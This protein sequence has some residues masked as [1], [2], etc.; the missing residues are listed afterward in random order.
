MVDFE[1]DS[2]TIVDSLHSIITYIT[3][4]GS[5]ISSFHN[6]VNNYMTNSHVEFVRRQ[7]NDSN[8]ALARNKDMHSF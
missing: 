8:H 6:I 5:N 2:T 1:L 7:T 3:K 4:F